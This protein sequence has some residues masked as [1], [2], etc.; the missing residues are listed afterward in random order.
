[1]SDNFVSKE[2]EIYMTGYEKY[3]LDDSLFYHKVFEDDTAHL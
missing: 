3:P 1:M 2:K